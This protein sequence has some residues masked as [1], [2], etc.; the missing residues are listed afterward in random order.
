MRPTQATVLSS[1]RRL[2]VHLPGIQGDGAGVL[3]D[4]GSSYDA[5]G[6]ELFSDIGN[7][8][9]LACLAQVLVRHCD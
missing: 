3:G 1:T 4:Q 2:G 8:A 9:N 6:G 7:R 5:N